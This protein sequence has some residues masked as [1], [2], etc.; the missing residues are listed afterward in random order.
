MIVEDT[1]N[2]MLISSP[3]FVPGEVGMVFEKAFQ[4]FAFQV[5]LI[6]NPHAGTGG[7][8]PDEILER[9]TEENGQQVRFDREPY[10]SIWRI[11]GIGLL[12]L[13]PI[14]SQL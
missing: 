12:S 13:L 8:L 2:E 1:Q 14:E 6:N 11:I 7:S 3:Y 5:R 4:T 10:V 9:V